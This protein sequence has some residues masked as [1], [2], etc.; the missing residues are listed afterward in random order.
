MRRERLHRS[1]RETC[2][3]VP[4]RPGHTSRRH[5]GEDGS[6]RPGYCK[7]GQVLLRKSIGPAIHVRR[8][9]SQRD[10][11]DDSVALAEVVGDEAAQESNLP[12]GG[13]HRPAGF[14]DRMGHRA[15]AAPWGAHRSN[16]VEPVGCADRD[17]HGDRPRR[18][19][20]TAPGAPASCRPTCCPR[21]SRACPRRRRPT[22]G[23]WSE[24]AIST[25]RRCGRSMSARR[26]SRRSISSRRSSTIRTCSGGSRRP[27][28]SRTCT[29]WVAGPRS[30]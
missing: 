22:R 10:G 19:S 7:I 5:R 21:R 15:P 9:F 11:S 14:E 13:L 12:T 3:T 16:A 8:P 6:G 26:S 28:P 25:T 17:R 27:T 18:S 4:M 23:C 24:T 29:R 2:A 30:P 1:T 20:P